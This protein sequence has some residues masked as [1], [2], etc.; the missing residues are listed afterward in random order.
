MS[1]EIKKLLEKIK[2]QGRSVLTYEESRKVMKLAGVP[3]NKM[4]IATNIDDCI[5][6]AN[7]IGYPVVLKIVSEDVIHKSDAGGVK[8]GIKSDEELKEA[9]EEMHKSVLKYYPEA[10]I[11]GVSIEEMVSG[12]EILIGTMTDMQ[13]GKMVALGVGGI[14][15]ELYKDVTFRLIPISES[16]VEE[17]IG[18][19]KGRKLF[20][21]YR[22]LPPVDK[23]E[24]KE[25]MLKISKLV[26]ENPVIKEMDLNPVVATKTGLKAIDARIILE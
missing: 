19:I 13:F 18:E 26:E 11:D 17:M 4:E 1:D 9:Y 16:D 2:E 14:F 5:S 12:A 6:K 10:K 7:E 21:G 8:V 22:G 23:K 3:L 15:T 24:L 25:I 20:D